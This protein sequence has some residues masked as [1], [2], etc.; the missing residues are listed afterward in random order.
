MRSPRLPSRILQG[1]VWRSNSRSSEAFARCTHEIAGVGNTRER[2]QSLAASLDAKG[3]VKACPAQAR[4]VRVSASLFDNLGG[5]LPLL[6]RRGVSRSEVDAKAFRPDLRL[7]TI[8]R[9][10]PAQAN[11]LHSI[12]PHTSILHHYQCVK[13]RIRLTISST[14]MASSIQQ[15][16]TTYQVWHLDAVQLRT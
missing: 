2:L 6:R 14:A 10:R 13:A 15:S 11:A 5:V 7:P 12:I 1:F 8:S 3:P 9:V 16:C 4:L